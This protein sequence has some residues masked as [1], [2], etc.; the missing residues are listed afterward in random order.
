[1]ARA[2]ELARCVDEEDVAGSAVLL[3]DEDAGV[4]AGRW[5]E[6]WGKGDD[7][8]DVAM[9]EKAAADGGVG[10]LRKRMPG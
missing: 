10:S 6:V 2:V 3:E 8:V 9:A 7:G 1:M 5:K 4:C